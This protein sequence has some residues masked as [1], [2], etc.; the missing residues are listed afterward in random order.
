MTGMFS[1][2]FSPVELEKNASDDSNVPFSA[3][4]GIN[5]IEEKGKLKVTRHRGVYTIYQVILIL[6]NFGSTP[7]LKPGLQ[8][9]A[10]QR[11]FLTCLQLAF[12]LATHLSGLAMTSFD[13][14]QAQIHTQVDA[15]FSPFGHPTYKL[16][17]ACKTTV[18][19]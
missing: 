15:S 19:T 13:F 10:S 11:K 9:D 1:S 6:E 7:C 5:D 14:G 18:Y 12:R 4:S 8:V 3:Q 16:M 17:V 2:V